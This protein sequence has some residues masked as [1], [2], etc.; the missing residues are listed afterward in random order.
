MNLN[1]DLTTFTMINRIFRTTR[2]SH[3]G[4][5]AGGSAAEAVSSVVAEK[6][7]DAISVCQTTGSD[8]VVAYPG[9]SLILALCG[10][11]TLGWLMKRR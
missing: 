7:H 8:W 1:S 2:G 3:D 6:A 5:L 9:T 4:S 10:G 11:A